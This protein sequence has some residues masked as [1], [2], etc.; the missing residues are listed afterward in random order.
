MLLFFA[1]LSCQQVLTPHPTHTSDAPKNW[2]FLLQ[3]LST[4]DGV[5]YEMLIAN[6]KTLDEYMSWLS[7]HGPHSENYSI[8]EERRKIVFYAN[9]YN[10]AVLYG[11]LHHWPIS[12]VQEVDVGWFTQE[13]VGFFLGQLFVIDG[14]TMSLFHLEQDL[15]LSQFQDPRIHVMLNCASRGCPP[16]RYWSKKGLYKQLD[17][18]WNTFIQNNVRRTKK[19][20]EV[21]ELF[22]WYQKD[23]LGWSSST[24]LCSYFSNYL[25]G[26]GAKWMN[27]HIGDCPLSSF[28]YDWSL[29]DS[30]YGHR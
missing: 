3:Q 24:S 20:W 12:S 7:I 4:D 14:G 5:N 6:R 1:L 22:F 11:V 26:E 13:N 16:L 29:N 2:K 28:P 21:S 19:G 23:L 18:H 9:A 15:L 8:R 10:A 17:I 25:T 30:P 27:K